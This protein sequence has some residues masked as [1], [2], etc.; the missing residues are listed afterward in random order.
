MNYDLIY[1]NRAIRDIKKLSPEIKKRIGNTLLRYKS[2][3]QKYSE[4]LKDTK[5]GTY[6]FRIGD[7]RVIFDIDDKKIVVLRLGHRKNIYKG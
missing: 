4:T 2:D 5:M 6:R 1:T 7:Y 3:P